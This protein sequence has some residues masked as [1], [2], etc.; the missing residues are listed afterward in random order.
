MRFA[1]SCGGRLALRAACKARSGGLH[2]ARKCHP[3]G[4]SDRQLTQQR[5]VALL[6]LGA[7]L[8]SA[9]KSRSE[10]RQKADFRSASPNLGKRRSEA[11]NV[12]GGY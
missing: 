12:N 8:L 1:A 2:P 3:T 10:P 9:I 11:L 7:Q 4:R 6:W 5:A